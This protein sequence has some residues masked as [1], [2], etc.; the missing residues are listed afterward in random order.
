MACHEHE[1][2]QNENVA[3]L[4]DR[5]DE[6]RNERNEFVHG[7]WDT[8]GCEAKTALIQTVNLDRT[9][10]IR[11]RLV[12]PKDLADFLADIDDW[13]NDYVILGRKLGFPRHRG[14]AKSIFAD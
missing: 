1:Q 8:T 2:Q 9:E 5:A 13:I 3:K 14:D 7:H 11:E 6:L 12:T 10:I 4:L